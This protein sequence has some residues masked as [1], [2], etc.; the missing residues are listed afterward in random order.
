MKKK[1]SSNGVKKP[2]LEMAKQPKPLMEVQQQQQQQQQLKRNHRAELE[3]HLGSTV[4]YKIATMGS[5]RRLAYMASVVVEGEQY[6]TYPQTF[7]SQVIQ[8]IRFGWE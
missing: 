5:A 1:L 3:T 4:P 6:K 7:P 8:T 2:A